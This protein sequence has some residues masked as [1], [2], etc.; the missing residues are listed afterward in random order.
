[1]IGAQSVG[2][3]GGTASVPSSVLDGGWLRRVRPLWILLAIVAVNMTATIA[4]MRRTSP[5]F[6]EIVLV[7]GGA[8]GWAGE[9][10]DL[11]PDHP[12]LMQYIYGLPVHLSGVRLPSESPPEI[13]AAPGFRYAYARSFYYEVGNDPRR[14]SFLGRLPAVL[15]AMLLIVVAWH[16][17]SRRWGPG[18]GLL[19]A[20][21]VAFL[22]DVLAHGGVAYNDLPLALCYLL[23]V[24]AIDGAVRQP[25]P[26]RGALAGAVVGLGLGVKISAA[27][28]VPTALI[29]IAMEALCRPR[30]VKWW[31]GLGVSVVT[32]AFAGYVVLAGIFLG[33]WDLS[34]FLYGMQYRYTHM[35]GG[36]GASAFLLGERSATGWWYFFPV[37][38]LF[39]TSAGLHLLLAVGVLALLRDAGGGWRP[40]LRSKL[41]APVAGAAVF[42]AILLTSNL[43]IGFRYALPAVPLLCLIAAVGTARAWKSGQRPTR[44]LIGGAT[45]LAVLFPLSYYPNFLGFISEYGPGRD[46]N[47]YV[48]VDSSLDWGQGLMQLS[49]YLERHGIDRVW[50]SYFGSGLPAAYGIDY[51]PLQSFFPLPPGRELGSTA[52]PGVLAI[53]ATNLNGGYMPGDIFARFR[54]IEPDAVV[55]HSILIYRLRP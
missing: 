41:R 42:V 13:R 46:R 18:A 22:P 50:L 23:G 35:T 54:D 49:E 9:A 51:E 1:M 15:I 52:E 36:H 21:L 30:D 16:V 34:D 25:S 8:R 3:M 48:L 45:V 31:S 28:L 11:A 29:I 17:T 44:L 47:H 32:A 4:G 53:S 33:D 26:G 55:A 19:A 7:A 12:P 40:V 37:A 14:V 20:A 6:D 5:T 39:K 27:A 38:F 24:F 10:F 2:T 43:N